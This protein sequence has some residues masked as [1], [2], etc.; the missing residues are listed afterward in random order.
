MIG[1]RKSGMVVGIAGLLVS[2]GAMLSFRLF[3]PSML[4]GLILALQAS[5]FAWLTGW[6][7]LA[8]VGAIAAVVPSAIVAITAQSWELGVV[9]ALCLVATVVGAWVARRHFMVQVQANPSLERP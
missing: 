8:L 4:I 9:P 3:P 2:A 5:A 1:S 7:R 6:H